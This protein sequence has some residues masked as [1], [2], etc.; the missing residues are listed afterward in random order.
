MTQAEKEQL[1]DAMAARST[2]LPETP[3]T[4]S[5]LITAWCEVEGA[6]S[7]PPAFAASTS[8]KHRIVDQL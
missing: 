2:R 3:G 4:T 1:G 7:L 5:D 6:P 8:T